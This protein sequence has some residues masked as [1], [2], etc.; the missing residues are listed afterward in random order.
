MLTFS[1]I[2]QLLKDAELVSFTSPLSPAS[3]SHLEVS[4]T[5]SAIYQYKTVSPAALL[6]FLPG[7]HKWTP[8]FLPS[9]VKKAVTSPLKNCISLEVAALRLLLKFAVFSICHS[10]GT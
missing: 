10:A 5:H 1:S 9:K 2:D 3:F 7:G 4:S 8:F 6:S